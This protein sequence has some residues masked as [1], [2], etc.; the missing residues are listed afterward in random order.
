MP[1]AALAHITKYTVPVKSIRRSRVTGLLNLTKSHRGH[2]KIMK[3][4][5][6]SSKKDENFLQ[7]TIIISEYSNSTKP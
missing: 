1:C 2:T 6:K 4:L 5:K 3:N 7:I